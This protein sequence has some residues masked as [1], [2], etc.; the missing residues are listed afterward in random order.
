MVFVWLGRS[1]ALSAGDECVGT[2]GVDS[3]MADWWEV[4][5]IEARGSIVVA[6]TSPL[7][8]AFVWLGPSVTL[9]AGDECVGTAGA[10]TD[11]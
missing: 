1:V 6:P 10:E 5:A 3:E 9:S 7:S 2:A 11:G 8:A 4:T